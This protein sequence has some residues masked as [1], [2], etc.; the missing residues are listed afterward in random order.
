MNSLTKNAMKRKSKGFKVKY[1]IMLLIVI[2]LFS[3]C[4]VVG[5]GV[6]AA[7]DRKTPDYKKVKSDQAQS[8][9]RGR[10]V[11]LYLDDG[12]SRS[13]EFQEITIEKPKKA[14]VS[15]IDTT[16]TLY[17]CVLIVQSPYF[18]VGSRENECIP[19]DSVSCIEVS[20][21][22]EAKHLGFMTGLIIDIVLVLWISSLEIS[23]DAM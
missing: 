15:D 12:S 14:I 8:L 1:S 21:I 5:L 2:I 19:I 11:T 23:I 17:E 20:N 7:I 16:L 4:S 3:G 22:K 9:E 10:D 6:G 18:P 13:G